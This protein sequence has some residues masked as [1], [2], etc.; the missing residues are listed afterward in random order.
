MKV[1]FIPKE[2]LHLFDSE[3]QAQARRLQRLMLAERDTT[4]NEMAAMAAKIVFPHRIVRI[5]RSKAYV[6]PNCN[7]EHDH[8][9]TNTGKFDVLIEVIA[10]NADKYF[11]EVADIG[12]YLSDLLGYH[13]NR[14]ETIERMDIHKFKEVK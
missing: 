7:I 2:D 13:G 11:S 3:K 6:A 10:T 12:V 5:I 9:D 14:E 8:Y 4:V 1:G